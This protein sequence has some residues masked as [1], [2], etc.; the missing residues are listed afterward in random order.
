MIPAIVAAWIV[1]GAAFAFWMRTW[2]HAS[3]AEWENPA[4]WWS[5]FAILAIAT[6]LD[7]LC[8]PVLALF[9]WMD[10]KRC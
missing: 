8:W 9:V 6:V 4:C 7:V 3:Y 10:R 1:V 5:V 2:R